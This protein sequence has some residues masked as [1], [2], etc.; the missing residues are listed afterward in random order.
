MYIPSSKQ[1]STQHGSRCGQRGNQHTHHHT[2]VMGMEFL[3]ST[4]ST[5][6]HCS[7]AIARKN[8]H[9][10]VNRAEMLCWNSPQSFAD[11]CQCPPTGCAG[12][13]HWPHNCDYPHPHRRGD[14]LSTHPPAVVFLQLPHFCVVLNGSNEVEL[15]FSPVQTTLDEMLH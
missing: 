9:T 14:L 3:S 12:Y 10:L 1:L 13:S 7:F 11:Q 2:R 4:S 15:W 6:K 5:N 8:C